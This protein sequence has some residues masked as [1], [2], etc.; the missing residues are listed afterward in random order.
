VLDE[1]DAT[2]AVR[3][4]FAVEPGP[5]MRDAMPAAEPVIGGVFDIAMANLSARLTRTRRPTG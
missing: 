4:T 1:R 3:W 2:T 5:E